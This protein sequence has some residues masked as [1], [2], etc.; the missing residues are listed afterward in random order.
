MTGQEQ[1]LE[2]LRT[3]LGCVS[4]SIDFEIVFAV[5]VHLLG[6][7][8]RKTDLPIP[9]RELAAL[10]FFERTLH[11]DEEHVVILETRR[12]PDQPLFR[13]QNVI[14]NHGQSAGRDMR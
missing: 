11:A 4:V 1:L 5:T 14:H 9:S 10:Q 12:A 6:L 3:F 7:L 13:F 8:S 2:L